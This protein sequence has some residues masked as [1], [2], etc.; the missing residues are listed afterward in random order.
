M[1]PLY[2]LVCTQA[3][4]DVSN[5]MAMKIGGGKDAV[6]LGAKHWAKFFGEIGFGKAAAVKRLR[7][8]SGAVLGIVSSGGCDSQGSEKIAGLVAANCDRLL[9]TDWALE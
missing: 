6:R 5:R 8:L 4:P 1:A 3:Y 9:S 2:D 7:G